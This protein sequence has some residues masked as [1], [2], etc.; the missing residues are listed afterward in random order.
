[1]DPG[2]ETSNKHEMEKRPFPPLFKSTFYPEN[3]L[4]WFWKIQIFSFPVQFNSNM[5][6]QHN[7]VPFF[8]FFSWF[9]EIFCIQVLSMYKKLNVLVWYL[10]HNF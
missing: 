4:N 6:F 3:Y 2:V 9:D 10:I 7:P 1:M 8:F 5:K